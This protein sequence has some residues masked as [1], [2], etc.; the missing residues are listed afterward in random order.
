MNLS[1]IIVVIVCGF[2]L[3]SLAC[4]GDKSTKS[5]KVNY[6]EYSCT[7]GICTSEKVRQTANIDAVK[8]IKK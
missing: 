7:N 5:S 8:K 1:K 4:D 6:E 3:S 2:S